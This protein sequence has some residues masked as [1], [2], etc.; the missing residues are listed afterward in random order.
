[1][2]QCWRDSTSGLRPPAWRPLPA[3]ALQVNREADGQSDQNMYKN[4]DMLEVADDQGV[5]GRNEE[6]VDDKIGGE[7][8]GQRSHMPPTPRPPRQA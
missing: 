7:G 2:E 5:V 8:G 3:A 1:M 6:E 4:N